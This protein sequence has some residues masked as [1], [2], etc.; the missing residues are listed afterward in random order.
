MARPRRPE[1]RRQRPTF[2]NAPDPYSGGRSSLSRSQVAAL[3]AHQ[4]G[5]CAVCRADLGPGRVIDHDHRLAELHG[6]DPA[7]ACPL[8]VRGILC[9]RCNSVLG[10]GRESYEYFVRVVEYLKRLQGDR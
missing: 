2:G 3:L 8:C 4:D 6:H 10:W 9:R 1:G 7:R 5:R